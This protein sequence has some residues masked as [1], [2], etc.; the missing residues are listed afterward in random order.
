M[1]LSV[2]AQS[3]RWKTVVIELQPLIA[4]SD[5]PYELIYRLSEILFKPQS[6][7]TSVDEGT[8]EVIISGI[9]FLYF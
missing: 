9:I 1:V 8:T 5:R 7:P 2:E 6:Y 4:L 3:H